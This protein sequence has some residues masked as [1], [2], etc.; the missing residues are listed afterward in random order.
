MPELPEVE[1]IRLGLQKYLVGHRIVDIEVRVPKIFQGDSE[2]IIGAK[3]VSIDRI[4]KAL[5]IELDNNYAMAIHLKLTGQIIYSGKDTGKIILSE[6]TGGNLPS[7][8][9]HVIF[10][11]DR[12]SF[13]Y[14]NDLRKFGWIKVVK[15]QE[16][17]QMT[18]FKE[19]G[20]E[21][22]VANSSRNNLTIEQFGNIL[23]KSSIPIK[24]LLM[25]QKR[26]GGIGNIYANEALFLAKIDPRRPSRQIAKAKAKRLYESILEVL[27]RGLKYGGSSD[28]NFVNAVG[29]DGNYQNH[30]LVYGRKG[31]K[32]I[33][34]SSLI[35]RIQLGGRGT[36]FC[37][38]CQ[39]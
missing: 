32:C 24:I 6:K 2:N 29:E 25:D 39:H 33:R 10:T 38:N 30:F 18:F 4:G 9:T 37:T 36:Y 20:P 27:K 34:C 14:Y 3:I 16:L 12:G 8:Y 19:L 13:L 15:K 28:A 31:K 5:I 1:T 35:K 23:S 17:M 22:P 26:I 11:L 7:K 21:F